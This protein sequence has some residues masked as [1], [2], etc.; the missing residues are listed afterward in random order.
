MCSSDLPF[1][2]GATSRTCDLKKL[3]TAQDILGTGE[4]A[5]GHYTQV[6]LTVSN[7][8][9]YFDTAS[10][11]AA[12]APAIVAPAGRSAV[13]DVPSGEVKLNRE[14]DITGATTTMLVDFDGDRSVRETG[15][16]RYLM[17]PVIGVVS[18]Q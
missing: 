14:F 4:L 13:V 8:A 3:Q 10:V 11:G 15:N 18:V 2:G 6:R 12:C 1:P 7:A 5:T 16:N 9:L 17:T